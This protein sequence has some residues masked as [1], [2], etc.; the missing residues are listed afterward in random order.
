MKYKL[1]ALKGILLFHKKN[2]GAFDY[3]LYRLWLLAKSGITLI[4]YTLK[5]D[6]VKTNYSKQIINVLRGKNHSL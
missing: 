2:Y 4:K 3:N 1:H 5:K 6:K